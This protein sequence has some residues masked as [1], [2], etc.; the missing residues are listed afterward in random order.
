MNRYSEPYDL[1]FPEPPTRVIDPA[2]LC[3]SAG[4][5]PKPRSLTT[6]Q[7]S[8]SRPDLELSALSQLVHVSQT[9][10][11]ALAISHLGSLRERDNLRET[12]NQLIEHWENMLN[13]DGGD[14]GWLAS[15]RAI[16]LGMAVNRLRG[17][18]V[19]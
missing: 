18:I 10:F 2:S 5:R 3:D 16:D 11:I 15:V 9:R 7:I 13:G 19:L 17:L 4:P 1:E 14:E 8:K 6:I 12:V